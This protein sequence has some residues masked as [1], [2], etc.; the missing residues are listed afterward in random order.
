MKNKF[1]ITTAI[2]YVNA[3]PHIGFT[4]ELI[5]ADVLARY[6]RQKGDDTML[7]A[8]ADENSLKN[9]QAAE[10]AGMP[11][12]DF[13]EQCTQKFIE[14]GKAVNYSGDDFVR[15]TEERHVKAAQKIWQACFDAGD[16]YKKSYKGLYCVGCEE[17]KTK[18]E[19]VDG[20]CPEH[21]VAPE[22]VDEENY[23]FRLSKYEKQLAGLFDG[24]MRIV[25]DSRGNE[26]REF[27]KGG[28]EDFSIS[29]SRA[30]AKNWGISVPGDDSQ[31]MYVW[32]DALVNYI[33]A[34]GYGSDDESLFEKYWTN[35]DVRCHLIGKGIT[36]FHA[37]YWPA[38][39]ISAGLKPPSTIYVHGY[40]TLDGEKISKS[41]GNTVDPFGVIEKFGVEVVRYYLLREIASDGD[42]DFSEKKLIDRYNGD[43]ANGL[44]NLVQRVATLIENNLGGE[45]VFNED[46][47][48]PE[49]KEAIASITKEKIEFMEQFR[50]HEA[51]GSIWKLI[52]HADRY[53]ND[54]KPWS[55]VKE[56]PEEFK[57]IMATIVLAIWHVA[58]GIQP[59]LP[60]TAEKIFTVFGTTEEPKV[61]SKLLV[62]KSAGLFPRLG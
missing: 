13:V 14:L 5:Q 20:L 48:N 8:G 44:G 34:L 49:T 37:I 51:L 52:T 33:T 19:L 16:I 32:F 18:K 39:L 50:L 47:V 25:P 10:K 6:H 41:L 11:V 3:D 62:K 30:R 2:P 17:F 43:L 61:G 1:Y 4:M 40:V 45:L 42:G 28:L 53:M 7:I 12:A 55:V 24:D 60:E 59:F 57:K 15:T 35:N 21:R 38:M 22:E 46:S 27:I 54:T 9:V 29:R 26:M 23:F 31:V 58:H 36:R 56:N